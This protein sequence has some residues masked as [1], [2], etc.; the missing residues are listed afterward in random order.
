MFGGAGGRGSRN[1]QERQIEAEKTHP[2]EPWLRGD[3]SES[4]ELPTELLNRTFQHCTFP[5]TSI[6][7]SPKRNR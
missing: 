3:D 2:P 1:P 4:R 6:P 7:I 5:T